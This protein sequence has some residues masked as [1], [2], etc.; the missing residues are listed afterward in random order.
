VRFNDQGLPGAF[1]ELGDG[2]AVLV[3]DLIDARRVA[4]LRVVADYDD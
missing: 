1:G 3:G 4:A 2:L